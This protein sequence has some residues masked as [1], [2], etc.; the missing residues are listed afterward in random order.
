MEMSNGKKGTRGCLRDVLMY[1]Y[2]YVNHYKG[3]YLTGYIGEYNYHLS[4][5]VYNWLFYHI[6]GL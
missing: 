4:K 5:R 3:F 6:G 2:I 1:I